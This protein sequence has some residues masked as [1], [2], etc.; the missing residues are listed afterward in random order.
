MFNRFQMFS[1]F[2]LLLLLILCLGEEVS[3]Q[4]NIPVSYAVIPPKIDGLFTPGEWDAH[5][6]ASGFIQ[7]EPDK[8]QDATEMT[9][10]YTTFDSSN[11]YVAFLCTQG[12]HN[13]IMANIQT[14]DR[15]IGGDDSVI[16]LLD[17]YGDS[18]SAC[19]FARWPF[20]SGVS[21]TGLRMKFGG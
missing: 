14:R 11:I 6:P 18:R 13:P 15:V 20:L 9:L 1:F 5:Q 10:V 12:N 4:K 19:G 3:G 7:M 17:T 2:R 21:S 8:G 16:L